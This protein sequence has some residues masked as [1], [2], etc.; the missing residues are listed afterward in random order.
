MSAETRTAVRPAVRRALLIYDGHCNF[1]RFWIGR[2]RSR[3]GRRI[4]YRRA[5]QVAT[6][7]PE[8]PRVEFDRAVQLIE[9]G[10]AVTSGADAVFRVFDLAGKSPLF[11]RAA[12]A[13]PGFVAAARIG[14][15]FIA[16]H[17]TTFSFFT[18]L[19][20]GR[21][22]RAPTFFIA[23][24]IFLRAL[25]AIY[26]IAFVSLL[27]QIRGL[28][29]A[30]GILPAQLWLNAVREQLSAER[31]KL[32]PTIFW[33]DASDTFL[34]GACIAGALLACAVIANFFPSACLL[35]LWALYL[36]LS[37]VGN[38]FLGYQWDALLLET[39]LL[40]VFLAP[41]SARPDWRA[42]PLSTRIARWLL[43]WLVF[44]LMFQSGLV[45]W[46]A[47]PS[48]NGEQTW[49]N[50]TALNYHYETQPL[51]IWTSWYLQ[52]SPLWWK[53][54]SVVAMFAIEFAAPFTL[55]A[56]ARVRRAGCAAMI[57]LQVLIAS[58]GNYT[59][60]N[61][62][63]IAL[64]VLALDDDCF[65]A[66]WRRL[67]RVPVPA[68][69][70]DWPLA[71]LAPVAAANL[72]VTTM[73][74]TSTLRTRTSWPHLCMKVYELTAP[75]RSFNSYGLF[76]V[77]TT[78]RPEI[79]VEGSNDG[80][81]WLPYEFKWKPGDVTR[82]PGVVAPHQPRLDWQMW[83]AALGDVRQNPWFLRFLQRLLEGS[84]EV[85]D[86]MEK[87]PFPAAP[88]R[89]LRALLYDYKFTRRGDDPKAWWKRE[90]RGVYCPAISLGRASADGKEDAD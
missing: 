23:R 25:G 71:L 69:G 58:S 9:P 67:A 27:L 45:K 81:T 68:H 47:P 63:T 75:L 1:C 42:N 50:L 78:S 52:Q 79:I 35:L 46:L 77:M 80:E 65:S 14:Y 88:P 13:V 36:S 39:G 53:K 3:T 31:F 8:I 18:R 34:Q 22:F 61:W 15:K 59:F 17:R 28:I 89:Y 41:L 5:Q 40:A 84:P 83:F 87:N 60:F 37:V 74:L 82:R 38:V 10:G 73:Q 24:W 56:P 55:L 64:C 6:R 48:E 29:G 4:G 51:P 90:E 76:A 62:L 7:F 70:R 12:R 43:L 86:L 66:H 57:G 21:A 2:W 72:L 26:L 11:L 20:W 30:H 32:A 19:L 54:F 44:R 33:L 49:R 85:L 16:R